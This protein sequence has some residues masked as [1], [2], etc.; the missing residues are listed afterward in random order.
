MGARGVRP[1]RPAPAGSPSRPLPL[2]ARGV[3]Q[4]A[5]AHGAGPEDGD[6]GHA[7]WRSRTSVL[8]M[9]AWCVA[10]DQVDRC[11]RPS[12]FDRTGGRHTW[13]GHPRRNAGGP[14]DQLGGDVLEEAGRQVEV[15]LAEQVAAK[16]M[17]EIET[18]L[19]RRGRK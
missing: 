9:V 2:E 6:P 16:G 14:F 1:A 3:R 10:L 15:G 11:C 18:S 13:L 7:N 5:H 19:S 4:E 8:D 17:K 12:R